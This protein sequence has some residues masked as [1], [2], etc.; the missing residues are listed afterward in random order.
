MKINVHAGHNPAGMI[1]SGAVGIL[2]ESVENRRIKDLVIQ[3]LRALGHTVYDCTVNDGTGQ[4][5]VLRKIVAKCNE[6]KVDLDISI[7]LNS[8]RNDYVGDGSIGGTE[9]FIYNLTA[10]ALLPAQNVVRE[11]AKLGYRIRDDRIKDNVKESTSLYVL[12]NTKAPAMLIECCFVDDKNDVDRYNAEAMANAIVK[13]I[14]EQGET[15]DNTGVK[16]TQTVTYV[17]DARKSDEEMAKEVI[18]GEWGN[19]PERTKKL[20]IAGYNTQAIRRIVNA[21]YDGTYNAQVAQPAV[22]YYPA[23]TAGKTLTEALNAIGV[24]SSYAN[25]SV[26]ATKNNVVG[27]RGTYN[28]NMTMWNL[29]KEGKLIS[30]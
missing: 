7:H 5:D 29:L 6:H 18:G 9:V 14:T 23:T 30:V 17:N 16:A 22:S 1:A 21:M 15:T 4:N 27:Y 12:R 24:N 3:K 25:R 26:I 19:D 11:I 20:A 10:G 28:Q 13:G 8:G 2:N